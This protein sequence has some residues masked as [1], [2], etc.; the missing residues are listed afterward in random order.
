[1]ILKSLLYILVIFGLISVGIVS[2]KDIMGES[3]PSLLQI[4][5]CY[6]VTIAYTL[7]LLALV[8]K[9]EGLKSHLFCAGWGASFTIALLASLAEFFGSG[10]VCPVSGGGS[11]RAGEVAT[12][13]PLCYMS[14]LLLVIIVT[15]YGLVNKVSSAQDV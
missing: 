6:I 3:C 1:M 10:G 14:L 11:L 9:K 13:I 8:T 4:P 15:L 2:V 12:G 5:V 7:I